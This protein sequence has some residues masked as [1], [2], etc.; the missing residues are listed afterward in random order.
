[1]ARQQQIFIHEREGTVGVKRGFS[2]PAFFFGSLWA[3]A[4]RMWVP[5]FPLLLVAD[6]ALWFLA[7][8]ADSR[9]EAG[10]DLAVLAAALAYAVG[11]GWYGNRWLAASLR[12]R[13]YALQVDP[14]ARQAAAAEPSQHD[15]P[16][17]VRETPGASPEK[18]DLVTVS[19]TPVNGGETTTYVLGEFRAVWRKGVFIGSAERCDLRVP[20]VPPIAAVLLALSN[21]KLL[22]LPDDEG[23]AQARNF[24]G[25]EIPDH[26]VRIDYAAFPVGAYRLQFGERAPAKV[27]SN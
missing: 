15:G 20:G 13:G 18:D 27:T 8:T 4:K 22:Y 25:G 14:P 16:L 21:H 10:L 2:W 1:M 23:F 6:V 11:R 7:G 9:K 12:R 5:A 26:G 17:I 19:V 24:T 3:A